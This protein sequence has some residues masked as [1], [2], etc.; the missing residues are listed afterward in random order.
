MIDRKL[1]FHI[2]TVCKI[3]RENKNDFIIT[4]VQ[5]IEVY[6]IYNFLNNHH[7]VHQHLL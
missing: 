3:T 2:F 5:N 1:A 7:S 4:I 6:D